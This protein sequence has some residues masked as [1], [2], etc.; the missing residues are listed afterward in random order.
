MDTK[1]WAISNRWAILKQT[2]AGLVF[3]AILA[4]GSGHVRADTNAV[5]RALTW[6]AARQDAN[7]KWSDNS[8]LNA[9]PLLACLSAGHTPAGAGSERM[10]DETFGDLIER[11]I[12]HILTQQDE[13][14]A[15]V[16]GNGM[17]YGHG[18]TTLLL[19]E[20]SGMTAQDVE[21]RQALQRA[22]DLILRS[23]QVEK[24]S[25]YR[26]G[27]RYHPESSDSDLSVT[28][29]QILALKAASDVG[30]KVPAEAIDRAMEFVG[31]CEHPQG[32]FGYQ[33]GGLSGIGRTAGALLVDKLV[34]GG[35]GNETIESRTW[36]KRAT[37]SSHDAF[38]YYAAH[39]MAHL[40]FDY[41]KAA[42]LEKQN[43][44]GSWTPVPAASPEGKAG[45]LYATAM[46]VL[47]LTADH[48]YLPV[49]LR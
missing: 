46:A 17:M 49:Y 20:V 18:I 15:F 22:V 47:A 6:L 41:G 1:S 24:S 36:L 39:N 45:P 40:G 19:A 10:A 3:L 30:I 9:L 28:V 29:W 26:G 23:Q 35:G 16:G 32:G 31:R 8:A 21:V 2:V 13:R 44:D 27:W 43:P 5:H 25:F 34:R 7:G 12:R 42:L 11:G 14:G 37:S 33:P 38:Y 4:A 48:H